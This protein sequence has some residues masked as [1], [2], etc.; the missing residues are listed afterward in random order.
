MKT[1]ALRLQWRK[2]KKII[3]AMA[4]WI[5]LLVRDLEILGLI[6]KNFGEITHASNLLEGTF[7]GQNRS[8]REEEVLHLSGFESMA[9]K[10]QIASRRHN[11][12]RYICQNLLKEKQQL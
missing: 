8:D 7:R 5:A 3:T 10:F 9:A 2:K 12:H 11:Q 1:V 6:P 4:Q